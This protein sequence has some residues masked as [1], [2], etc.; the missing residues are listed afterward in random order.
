MIEYA[1]LAAS[2][3]LIAA[4]LGTAAAWVTLRRVMDVDFA[5]S[6]G[7]LGQ[8]LGL[9]LLLVGIFGAVGTWKVL[10]ARTVPH[11]RGE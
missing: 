6:L 2:T 11:L 4:V 5:L 1:L 9:S 7:A 8:A 10:Q 3:S